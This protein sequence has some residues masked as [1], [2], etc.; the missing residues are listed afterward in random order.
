MGV[1]IPKILNFFPKQKLKRVQQ[2]KRV[3]D[4]LTYDR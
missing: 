2:V 4:P 1:K 3:Q